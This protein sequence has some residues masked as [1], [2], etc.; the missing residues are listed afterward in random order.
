M[1]TDNSLEIVPAAI[2]ALRQ[3][4][5]PNRNFKRAGIL[6]MDIRGKDAALAQ[7]TLF[8]LDE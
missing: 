7:Q 3:V 4:F 1:P 8:A 2:R 6:L 5:S